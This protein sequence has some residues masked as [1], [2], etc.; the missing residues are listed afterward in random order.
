MSATVGQNCLLEPE[1][2]SVTGVHIRVLGS[3][4]VGYVHN[5]WL[6]V[7]S[8]SHWLSMLKV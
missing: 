7:Y 2:N 8:S 5:Y 6:T 3:F 4:I 1:I